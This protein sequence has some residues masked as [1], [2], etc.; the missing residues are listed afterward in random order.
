MHPDGPCYR[1]KDAQHMG[2]LLHMW[3]SHPPALSRFCPHS[4]HWP[5]LTLLLLISHLF[6]SWESCCT[7]ASWSGFTF[8]FVS[9][10]SEALQLY[11]FLSPFTFLQSDSHPCYHLSDPADV[12]AC[13]MHGGGGSKKTGRPVWANNAQRQQDVQFWKT[14]PENLWNR[15]G[16]LQLCRHE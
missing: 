11:N 15:V 2:V 13:I 16:H 4:S 10:T 1:P 9:I 14:L 7:A 5:F 8:I 12:S 3:S 6:S